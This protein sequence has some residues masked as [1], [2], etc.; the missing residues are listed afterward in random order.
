[1]KL[2]HAILLAGILLAG[3]AHAGMTSFSLTEVARVRFQ[4]LSFFIVGYLFMALIVKWLWN[5][6]AISFTKLPKLNYRRALTLSLIS[7]LF[8]YVILTIIS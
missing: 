2:P 7:G 5:Y 4:T 8:L 3:T 6:L 1:M